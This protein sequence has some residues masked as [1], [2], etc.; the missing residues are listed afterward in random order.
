VVRSEPDV[1]AGRLPPVFIA[2]TNR[3]VIVAGRRLLL[4]HPLPR[5]PAVRAAAFGARAREDA[6]LDELAGERGEMRAGER[7]GGD[8]PDGA[9]IAGLLLV[10]FT[11]LRASLLVRGSLAHV[12]AAASVAFDGFFFHRFGVVVVLRGSSPSPILRIRNVGQIRVAELIERLHPLPET[13]ELCSVFVAAQ[14]TARP[15]YLGPSFRVRRG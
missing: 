13:V 6:G 9:A 2:A 1:P 5:C 7:L 12:E 4:H 8:G 15:A 3:A 14:P 11:T 10:T